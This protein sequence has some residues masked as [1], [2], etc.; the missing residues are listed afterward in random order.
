MRKK[1]CIAML[2]AGGQGSRL[3]ALTKKNAKPAV[4]FGGKYRIIDF[5]LSNCVSSGIDTVGVLTQY[6][7]MVLNAYLGNG[8]AWDLDCNNGGVHVLPPYETETGGSWYLGTADAIYHNIDFIDTYDPDYVL[9]LSG[10]HLYMMDYSKMLEVHKENQA[11][12]TVS[13]MTV[14]WEEAS[15]FGI[16][17]AD[18]TGRIT[19][20]V[21][22]PP[23]PTSNLASM[24]IY[25]FSWPVLR[26]SLIEDHE[27]STSV[28]DF[29]K[30]IIPKMLAAQ[31]R[32]FVYQ[33]SGYWKDVGTIDSYYSANM[34]LLEENPPLDLY[35]HFRIF[36]NSNI[37]PPHFVG[38]E[39]KVDRS[40]VSNGCRILGSVE[41][42]VLGS[43]VT[44]GLGALVKDSILLPGA[45]IEPGAK[46]YR[47]IVAERSTILSGTTFGTD[48]ESAPIT[49][50]GD[51]MTNG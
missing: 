33:F 44:V 5:S 46:V 37:Y 39:G 27:D 48:D 22:K 36:S 31:N 41:H 7:P 10:D 17:E 15:R 29:G 4:S 40:I 2:L 20:F 24:G 49:L 30:N 8:E 23:Q 25:I 1:E 51:D 11:D 13:V 32:L 45:V 9:I 14:P 18:E 28:H 21:E 50:L 3:L 19:Q 6:K 26:Q 47:A 43:N 38:P 34:E 35:G 12:L 42:S 16:M